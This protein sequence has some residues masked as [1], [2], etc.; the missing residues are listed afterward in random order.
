M[1][2]LLIK[3]FYFT[4]LILQHVLPPGTNPEQYLESK[5]HQNVEILKPTDQPLVI[6]NNW[7]DYQG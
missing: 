1:F 6:K 2:K 5:W 7:K 4:F 3:I